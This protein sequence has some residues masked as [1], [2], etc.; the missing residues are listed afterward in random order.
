MGKNKDTKK[1]STKG[2]GSKKKTN[3]GGGDGFF[4]P[5]K[6]RVFVI[7]VL[8]ILFAVLQLP[9]ISEI[10]ENAS[11]AKGVCHDVCDYV[12]SVSAN[13]ADECDDSCNERYSTQLAALSFMEI[14]LICMLIGSIS[15]LVINFLNCNDCCGNLGM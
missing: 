15:A 10:L 13:T 6:W 4:G 7:G 14:G 1:K 12:S 2:E 11:D 9:F 3:E 5:I 8:L